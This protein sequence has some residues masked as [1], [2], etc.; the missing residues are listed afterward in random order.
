VTTIESQAA[1]HVA[2]LRSAT[3]NPRAVLDPDCP[4][5]EWLVEHGYGQ[6]GQK[7]S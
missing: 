7:P 2:W 4:V 3:E 5:C 1:R 6:F